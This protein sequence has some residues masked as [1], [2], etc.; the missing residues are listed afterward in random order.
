MSSVLTFKWLHDRCMG[1]CQGP[2]PRWASATL[3]SAMLM[4]Q[5]FGEWSMKHIGLSCKLSRHNVH[6]SSLH[7]APLNTDVGFFLPDQTDMDVSSGCRYAA[8][9][10]W[11]WVCR[12]VKWVEQLGEARDEK[13]KE[14]MDLLEQGVIVPFSGKS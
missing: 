1:P 2:L 9:G 8:Y 12:M 7:A 6:I 3:P 4:S 10:S 13:L 5:D 14:V 11:T